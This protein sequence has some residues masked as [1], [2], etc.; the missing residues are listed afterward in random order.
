M[1]V[2]GAELEVAGVAGALAAADG[3]GVA[4]GDGLAQPTKDTATTATRDI[5]GKGRVM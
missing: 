5:H 3:I 2:A 1:S 4:S